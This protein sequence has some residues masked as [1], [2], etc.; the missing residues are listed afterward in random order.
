MYSSEAR[1]YSNDYGCAAHGQSD[2]LCDVEPLEGGVPIRSVPFAGR[3]LALGIDRL[4]LAEWAEEVRAWQDSQ[5]LR[6]VAEI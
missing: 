1:S 4:G 3:L 5:C 2:C 6:L